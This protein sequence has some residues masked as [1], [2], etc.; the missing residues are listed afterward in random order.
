[1]RNTWGYDTRTIYE[2]WARNIGNYVGLLHNSFCP[3]P[4]ADTQNTSTLGFC[5]LHHMQERPSADER[6]RVTAGAV[7]RTLVFRPK[8]CKTRYLR[9]Q[10]RCRRVFLWALDMGAYSGPKNRSLN[11]KAQKPNE[12]RLTEEEP[13]DTSGPLLNSSWGV[14]LGCMFLSGTSSVL[15]AST[16]LAR[17]S[18]TYDYAPMAPTAQRLHSPA[19]MQSQRLSTSSPALQG[20]A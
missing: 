2:I 17:R 5:N 7:L 8:A 16:C 12:P 10:S 15:C 9:G 3:D 11:K 4:W 14:V 6:A 20:H 19:H 1:M 13:A 18:W